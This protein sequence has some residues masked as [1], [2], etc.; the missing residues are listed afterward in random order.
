MNIGFFGDSYV[1]LIWYRY[2]RHQESYKEKPWSLR[3]LEEMNSP[4][5]S[6]GLGG[7]NLYYAIHNWNNCIKENRAIDY[8]IFTFTWHKRLF[9]SI[10]FIQEIM[11]ASAEKRKINNQELKTAINLY[12]DYIHNDDYSLFTYKLMTKWILDLPKQYHNTKFIFIPNTEHAREL[13]L[14]DFTQGIAL[15]FAFET[16]SNKETNS[17]GIMPMDCGRKGH[18]NDT[19]HERF[20][21]LMK[22]LI[23]NYSNYENSVYKVDYT[24]FDVI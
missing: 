17:P 9:H 5:I 6:S 21:D 4:I 8:A 22:D 20:K 13:V 1:D 16:L 2:P 24:N 18:L 3:L 12:Y 7:S 11:S 14:T 15:D 19:N 23:L 10:E